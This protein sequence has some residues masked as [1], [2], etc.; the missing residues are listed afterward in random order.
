MRWDPQQ[1]GRYGD[2]RARPFVDLVA[3]IGATDPRRVVD[4]GCGTGALTALLADRWPGAEVDGVDSSAEM[5]A[6]APAGARLRFRQASAEDWTMPVD[7]DV[8]LSNALLQWVPTHRELLARWAA[9]LPAGGW[10]AFQVPGNFDAPSHVAMRELAAS[11]RWAA[12]LD[13]VLR[14]GETTDSA[15]EYA[16][17]LLDAGLRVDA[18]ETTYVHV[19]PGADPVLEWLR[20]TGL[21]PVLERLS[22]DD[23]GEFERELADRLRAAYP[24]GPQGTL[25]PFRRIVLAAV[26][27]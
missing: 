9:R 25:L 24:P 6:R 8:L 7:T 11:P 13:G 21:R 10:L 4:L 14:G 23:A 18:W 22:P 16:Q 20:G 27:P 17:L 5:I 15:A 1:Y 12:Q 26:K 3:R 2:E 19:L